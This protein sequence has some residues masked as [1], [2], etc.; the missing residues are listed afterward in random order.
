MMKKVARQLRWG[1]LLVS[2]F[3]V[4][5]CGSDEYS[6]HYTLT[7]VE[8]GQPGDPFVRLAWDANTEPD[9]AGY[10]VY[11]SGVSGWYTRWKRILEIPA[12][13][14]TC[15][16]DRL[17][18]GTYFWVVTAFDTSRNESDYSNEV[19]AIMD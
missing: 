2:A 1:F 8:V 3:L 13:I 14:E 18:S 11:Q 19:S 16:I 10:W 6:T 5:A 15:R 17:A 9:L 7:G 12:G 4:Y